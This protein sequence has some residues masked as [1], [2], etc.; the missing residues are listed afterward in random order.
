MTTTKS[1]NDV[2]IISAY[3]TA[4]TK[5]R[6]GLLKDKF[7][8]DLLAEVISQSVSRLNIKHEWI[9]DIIVGTVLGSNLQRANEVRMAQFL[10]GLPETIPIHTVNR[11]CG[12]GL[13]AI[14]E[15]AG[16]I[17]AGFYSL[18]LACGVESMST[19]EFGSTNSTNP[20]VFAN[21]QAKAC[22]LPIGLT[23]EQVAE[24]YGITREQQDKFAAESHRRAAIAIKSG[25]FR[26]EILPVAVEVRDTKTGEMH[27]VIVDCDDGVRA[28]TNFENLS[29]LKPA[30]SDTGASTAGNSSQ[31]S[32]GAACVIVASRRFAEAH[33][34]PIMATFRSFSVAGVPPS[35]MGIGPVFAIPSAIKMAGLKQ[36]QIGLF[37]LNEAFASQALYCVNKLNLP[38]DRVNVN[39]GAIAL[40]HPLGATGA[41]MTAT[42]LHEMKKRKAK[43]GIVSMCIGS[44]MGAAAVYEFEE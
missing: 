42:L 9:G 36:D 25:R 24:D 44:G 16:Q 32:D 6:R 22:M 15:A 39:G 29:K 26:D 31:V 35:V 38:N 40:G 37:E 5:A 12:S 18:A 27:K 20:R 8:E 33:G 11:Q 17:K 21:A 7:V 13:Q 23:S 19:S 3:R 14:A 43:F 1:P 34:L 41:R 2:V 10:A 30:F 28:N 4:I